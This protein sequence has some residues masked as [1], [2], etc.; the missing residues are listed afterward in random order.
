MINFRYH[1]VSLAAVFLALAIGLVVGTAAANGPLAD[2]LNNQVNKITDEKE[3]LRDD[4]DQSRAELKKNSD[5]ATEVAPML[6]NGKLAGRTALLVKIDGSDK[7]VDTAADGIAAML[8]TA[9]AKLTGTVTVKEKFTAAASDNTLLDLAE[10][11]APPAISGALPNNGK[12]QETSAALLA[13]VLVADKP[14]TPQVDGARA[15]LSAY[16]SGGYIGLDGDLKTPADVVIVV[17]GAP[18]TGKDAKER[19]AAAL[20]VVSRLD[21]ALAGDVVVA[22]LS[23]N[24]LVS[25]VRDDAS[26]AK[27]VSTV[28][29][30]FTAYGQV[31]AVMALV[32]RLGG[33]TGHYGIGN[34][35]TSLL[36]KTASVTSGS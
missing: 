33:K 36:P 35:A 4:L 9:G 19:N 27:D 13:A 31:A 16:Q 1:V 14:G 12:G 8:Q 10:S 23:A 7:D 17:A 24:G 21:V 25:S 30:A 32:E 28:D 22:G 29:N 3:Q 18:A 6:L 15:V 5:F 20:T 26:I 34:G 11:S 2:D